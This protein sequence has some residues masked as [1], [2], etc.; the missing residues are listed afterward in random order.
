MTALNEKIYEL[1]D[2]MLVIG[3]ANGPDD[4]AGIMGGERTGV[5]ELTKSMFLEVAIF[6]QIS[7]ATT[8]RKL[9]IHSDPLVSLRARFGCHLARMGSGYVARMVMDIC[10]GEGKPCG[11]RRRWGYGSVPSF[12]PL[13]RSSALP[14][15]RWQG[16]QIYF[17]ITWI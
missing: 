4:L 10:G 8:G 13:I 7:V 12:L 14:A 11:K 3:D 2:E 6:D 15:L 17:K 16:R 5:S 1:D 9:N